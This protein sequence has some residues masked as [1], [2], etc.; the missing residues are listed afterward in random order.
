MMSHPVS[1]TAQLGDSAAEIS[2]SLLLTNTPLTPYHETQMKPQTQ[3]KTHLWPALFFSTLYHKFVK[4]DFDVQ[5][6]HSFFASL[7]L[8]QSFS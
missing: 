5:K 7:P 3:V 6:N 4:P 1:Q 8:F 2:T